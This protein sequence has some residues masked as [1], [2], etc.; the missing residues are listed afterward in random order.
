LAKFG[1]FKT[2][3]LVLLAKTK[4]LVFKK[5]SMASYSANAKNTF[6]FAM[7]TLEA[8]HPDAGPSLLDVIVGFSPT[9]RGYLASFIKAI[10]K[11]KT[12]V[13]DKNEYEHVIQF[14]RTSWAGANLIMERGYKN[15]PSKRTD[16]PENL[17]SHAAQRTALR[18]CTMVATV[19]PEEEDHI[20]NFDIGGDY[21]VNEDT[22]LWEIE[23]LGEIL[24]ERGEEGLLPVLRDLARIS[25]DTAELAKKTLAE[26]SEMMSRVQGS[27]NRLCLEKLGPLYEAQ[28]I[29]KQSQNSE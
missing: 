15:W 3:I 11:K 4:I 22:P 25:G 2:K 18:M 16:T 12:F 7:E 8:L 24:L 27:L 20:T 13:T 28:Q 21:K 10:I 6:A 17:V 23:R 1:P 14:V 19:G 9:D 26:R 5:R 29:L